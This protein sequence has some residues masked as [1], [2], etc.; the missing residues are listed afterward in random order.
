VQSIA[1]KLYQQGYISY[2]RTETEVFEQGTDLNG[3]I[4]YICV[5]SFWRFLPTLNLCSVQTS[6]PNWGEYAQGLLN[7]GFVA[8]RVGKGNDHSHPP[9]HPIKAGSNLHGMS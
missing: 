9:I 8:P 3:L 7:G 2:P 5:H 6:D 4:R 1:E